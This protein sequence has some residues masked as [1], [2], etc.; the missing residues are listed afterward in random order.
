MMALARITA[1]LSQGQKALF[2]PDGGV[3]P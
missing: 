2:G 3:P 1:V